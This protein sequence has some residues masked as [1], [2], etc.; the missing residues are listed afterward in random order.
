MSPQAESPRAAGRGRGVISSIVRAF[1]PNPLL[2]V[3]AVVAMTAIACQNWM[4]DPLGN[5]DAFKYVG[6]FVSFEHI[7]PAILDYKTA[8]LPWILPGFVSYHL[9]GPVAGHYVLQMTFL[10]A[11]AILL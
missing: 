8:R 6:S 5:T 11:A 1:D 2:L 3:L 9:F 7:D 10:S 4:F